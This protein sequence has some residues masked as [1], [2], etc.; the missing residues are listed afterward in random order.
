MDLHVKFDGK[1]IIV[2]R[3]GTVMTT[4]YR[5]GPSGKSV[6]RSWLDP[7]M[8]PRIQRVRAQPFKLRS[9]RRASSGGLCEASDSGS[10]RP[11]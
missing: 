3:P 7:V 6:L 10:H 4:A 5:K 1:E 11:R 8:S 9:A 2:T